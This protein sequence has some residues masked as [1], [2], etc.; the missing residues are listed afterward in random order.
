MLSAHT[1]LTKYYITVCM[2]IRNYFDNI[3]MCAKDLLSHAHI[4][5]HTH[6]K[7]T[8]ENFNIQ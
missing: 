2:Y 5:P 6:M 3:D 4:H 8:T 7:G 1:V